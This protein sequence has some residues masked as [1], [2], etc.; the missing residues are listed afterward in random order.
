MANAWGFTWPQYYPPLMSAW[1]K[2]K[3]GWTNPINVVSSGSFTLRQTCDHNDMLII[4]DPFPNGEY[5][6]IENRQPCGFDGS[7][8]Q[9]GIVIFHIDENAS[10]N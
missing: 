5:L 6:L 9:G 2:Y 10:N 7:M 8:P 4:D 3:L 1:S